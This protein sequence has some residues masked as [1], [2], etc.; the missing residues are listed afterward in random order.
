MSKKEKVEPEV[1]I[2]EII[3][4][5]LEDFKK[6]LI[7]QHVNIGTINNLI[8]WFESIYAELSGRRTAIIDLVRKGIRAKDDEEV[9]KSLE[10]L[11]AEML[12]IEQKVVYLKETKEKLLVF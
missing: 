5:P 6:E 1:N 3:D 11:Y 4:M 10:G 12:K 7:A 2:G 9:V 8:L